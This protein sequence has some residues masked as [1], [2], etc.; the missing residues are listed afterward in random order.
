MNDVLLVCFR[1]VMICAAWGAARAL[2]EQRRRLVL[3]RAAR[4]LRSL[5]R[6]HQ[7][8]LFTRAMWPR[9]GLRGAACSG[10]IQL[11][12]PRHT[13]RS[14]AAQLTAP[15]VAGPHRPH[16]HH[17]FTEHEAARRLPKWR[18]WVFRPDL[19]AAIDVGYADVMCNFT[20]RR[21]VANCAAASRRRFAMFCPLF[22]SNQCF[23]I[24]IE[25]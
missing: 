20:R 9:R 3:A 17:G 2:G 13:P 11:A 23:F 10:V 19:T 21:R 24:G 22:C 18:W 12:G 14:F 7:V 4:S 8:G 5:R 6:R 15:V 16:C 1:V 25:G